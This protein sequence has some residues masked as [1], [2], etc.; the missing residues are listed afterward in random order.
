MKSQVVMTPWKW[1]QHGSPKRWYPTAS[2]YRST[3][4]NTM[5]WVTGDAPSETWLHEEQCVTVRIG[6]A[7]QQSV[8]QSASQPASQSV[9]A[10]GPSG[11]HD[12][13]LVVIKWVA[14]FF[15][16][17]GRILPV[18]RTGLSRNKSQ[19]LSVSSNKYIYMYMGR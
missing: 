6:V 13:I 2:L 5:I 15:F 7:L 9:L 19:Y 10:L 14:N 3:T 18:E 12:Q 1:R 4:Q 8:S 16:F 17:R 11:S